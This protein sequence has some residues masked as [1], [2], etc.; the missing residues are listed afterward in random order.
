MARLKII[1]CKVDAGN[2]VALQ[3]PANTFEATINPESYSHKFALNYTG[4][5]RSRGVALNSSAP[6][7][8]FASAE[9]EKLDF[10][11]VLDGTGVVPDPQQRTVAQQ[12]DQLRGIAYEYDGEEHEPT[13]VKVIWGNG[14]RAFF[15]RLT[16]LTVNYTLFHP[17]GS[18]LRAKVELS[19]IEAKTARQEALEARRSSPDLTHVVRVRQ[20][21]TLPLLCH[22]IYKDAGKYLAIARL[23]DLDGL[24]DLVPGTLLR[25]PPMR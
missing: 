24:R 3:G 13:P 5:S 10:S 15:G 12:I 16:G 7:E 25:F 17:D 11:I 8:K 19:L 22:R 6:V 21:D 9:P 23:N 18:A 20:G 14:L 4:D 1:R 2:I